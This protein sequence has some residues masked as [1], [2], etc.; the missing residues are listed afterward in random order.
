MV[1][2]PLK[3]S[4]AVTQF[5]GSQKSTKQI[6]NLVVAC[7]TDERRVIC[8][9]ESGSFSR[10]SFGTPCE[11]LVRLES[12]T[13]SLSV[14]GIPTFPNLTVVST[15]GGTLVLDSR[16]G[17]LLELDQTQ[18]RVA[19]SDMTVYCGAFPAG[20]GVQATKNWVNVFSAST[21]YVY[22]PE[23]GQKVIACASDIRSNTIGVVLGDGDLR[24]RGRVITLELSQDGRLVERARKDF[25][26]ELTG[27]VLS[28]N[29]IVVL[30]SD[31]SIQ[32]LDAF[33]LSLKSHLKV[34]APLKS[35]ACLEDK[36]LVSSATG[37]L[38]EVGVSDSGL[39]LL[40]T[41]LVANEPVSLVGTG[42]QF[43]VS[44]NRVFRI[45]GPELNLQRLQTPHDT[46]GLFQVS[47]SVI[48]AVV[49]GDICLFRLTASALFHTQPLA[50]LSHDYPKPSEV[51]AVKGS[52]FSI[53]AG[54][55]PPLSVNVFAGHNVQI[56]HSLGSVTTACVLEL[57]GA[58]CILSWSPEAGLVLTEGSVHLWSKTESE[59]MVAM[60][61][62][63]PT[64]AICGF[65]SGK[66]VVMHISRSQVASTVCE[67]ST[68]L[69]DLRKLVVM[70]QRIFAITESTGVY[71]LIFRD[72]DRALLF[73]AL[74]PSNVTGELVSVTASAIL[75][76]DHVVI[77][78]SSGRMTVMRVPSSVRNDE[79]SQLRGF[80]STADPALCMTVMEPVAS[81]DLGV[82]VLAAVS[83]DDDRRIVYLSTSDGRFW[84]VSPVTL[85]GVE[86][87]DPVF[88]T[89][90]VT[91][92]LLRYRLTAHVAWD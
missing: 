16:G 61:Q 6:S 85:P 86:E 55:T 5:G 50:S 20:L 14:F 10:L 25:L 75:D 21:N 18:T 27:I 88:L 65:R 79:K 8:V 43:A 90:S 49:S 56:L 69:T 40:S 45:S 82:A 26:Q 76:N 71:T 62:L 66:L 57:E 22:K 54:Q 74:S 87:T 52:I 68:W 13:K 29:G 37:L 3:Q 84:A 31:N 73:T 59:K 19:L 81:I 36:L 51:L 23:N 38:C 92:P 4:F 78:E 83:S 64:S 24:G 72:S 2:N 35:I 63:T 46:S 80:S 32:L 41:R 9:D 44:Q 48:A 53:F 33:T 47:D 89:D 15:V 77:G 39:Q 28:A 70:D 91:D 34:N 1:L 42:V 11:L 12:P 67:R 58:Q 60:T 7:H 30:T 17:K